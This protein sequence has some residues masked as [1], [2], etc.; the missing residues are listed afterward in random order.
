MSVIISMWFHTLMI[1][2]LLLTSHL[3]PW[4]FPWWGD[5]PT[6]LSFSANIPFF[7]SPPHTLC[8]SSC[9]MGIAPSTSS[10]SRMEKWTKENN[11]RKYLLVWKSCGPCCQN[12]HY[13]GGG[14]SPI[15]F[16]QLTKTPKHADETQVNSK[17]IKALKMLQT[18]L[19][20]FMLQFTNSLE[21]EPVSRHF[22]LKSTNLKQNGI[23][24]TRMCM[25][26]DRNHK[27]LGPR[28][29]ESLGQHKHRSIWK[30]LG[31]QR[32]GGLHG[33]QLLK[34]PRTRRRCQGLL[35]LESCQRLQTY[36]TWT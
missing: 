9:P 36:M 32:F 29:T 30:K 6:L 7:N 27:G 23:L 14:R 19:D 16:F 28:M 12:G 17:H 25:L 34:A 24:R 33:S 4:L 13:S 1:S 15:E 3:L 8:R 26:R 11:Q 5:A 35:Q 2:V 22:K 31:L 20:S 18:Q 21:L 10:S